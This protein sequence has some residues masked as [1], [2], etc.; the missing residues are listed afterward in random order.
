MSMSQADLVQSLIDQLAD[1]ASVFENE[2]FESF[3]DAAAADLSQYRPRL[4]NTSLTLLGDTELYTAPS[5]YISFHSSSWGKWERRRRK[6]WDENYPSYLPKIYFIE[7]AGEKKLFLSPAPSAEQI[8]DFGSLYQFRYFATHIISTDGMK[9]SILNS[10]R[11]LLLLR[12]MAEA[13]KTMAMRNISKPVRL[14]DGLSNGP[15]NGTPAALYKQ[16]MDEF[17]AQV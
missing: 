5:D 10:D 7:D 9:T 2:D 4:M 17:R 14:R 15:R 11:H 16:L 12:A 1:S 13:A 6:V 3:L 8:S